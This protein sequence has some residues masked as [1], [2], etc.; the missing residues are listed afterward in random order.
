MKKTFGELHRWLRKQAGLTMGDVAR[1]LDVSVSFVSDVER[2]NRAPFTKDKIM[3]I[4][5]HLDADPTVLL[6]A[7]AKSRGSFEL[8]TA[9]TSPKHMEVGAVLM[10]GWASLSEEDLETISQ[11]VRRRGV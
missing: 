11:I 8:D 6:S 10:R 7:A 9:N 3:T 2:D 4:S 1:V 5:E